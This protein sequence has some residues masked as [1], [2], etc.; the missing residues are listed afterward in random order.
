M[1]ISRMKPKMHYQIQPREVAALRSRPVPLVQAQVQEE[2]QNFLHALDSY[3]ARVAKEPRVSFH[4][5]LCSL[6]AA[7][8][9]NRSDHRSRRRVI[10]HSRL[11]LPTG[12]RHDPVHAQV[13]HHLS[14]V[15]ETMGCDARRQAQTRHPSFSERTLYRLH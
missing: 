1:G 11:H 14:V 10:R 9:D 8:G 3:P 2:I 7:R 13:F 15:V 12:R 4:Q 6:F 5:H